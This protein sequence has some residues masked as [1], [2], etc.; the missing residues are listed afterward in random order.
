ML[1][2]TAPNWR[3]WAL[4]SGR[5][6]ESES[7]NHSGLSSLTRDGDKLSFIRLSEF[8]LN[9]KGIYSMWHFLKRKKP[10]DSFVCV[11]FNCDFDL[12]GK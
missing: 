6:F 12:S 7:R 3:L 2:S 1:S 11:F 9:I 8:F 4:A 5:R 10:G